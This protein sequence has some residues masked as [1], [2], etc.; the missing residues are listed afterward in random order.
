[1]RFETRW[2]STISRTTQILWLPRSCAR[3]AP[4]FQ[5]LPIFSLLLAASPAT[6]YRRQPRPPSSSFL[7]CIALH[8]ELRACWILPFCPKRRFGKKKGPPPLTTK[9]SGPPKYLSSP[10]RTS[11][12]LACD[13]RRSFASNFQLTQTPIA[14]QQ[15]TQPVLGKHQTYPRLTPKTRR[16]SSSRWVRLISFISR[17]GACSARADIMRP[18]QYHPSDSALP[19]TCSPP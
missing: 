8:C 19:T 9:S 3:A 4:E 7:H 15:Q 13:T 11:L 16:T 1:M 17:R 18:A 5:S 10:N 6:R 2:G 12:R 14:C